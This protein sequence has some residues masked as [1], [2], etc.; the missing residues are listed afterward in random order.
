MK[1][2]QILANAIFKAITMSFAVLSFS[3]DS[4]WIIFI[5]AIV[6]FLSEINNILEA[7]KEH[8]S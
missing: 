5:S 8:I 7:E 4:K 6:A 1:L 2:I 3:A